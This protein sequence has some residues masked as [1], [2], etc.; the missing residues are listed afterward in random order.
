MSSDK[1]REIP[2]LLGSLMKN[3]FESVQLILDLQ[4]FIRSIQIIYC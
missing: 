3:K 4:T 2:T 1:G